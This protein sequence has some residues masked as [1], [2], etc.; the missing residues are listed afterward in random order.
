MSC[1][2]DYNRS[3]PTGKE[4][5][6]PCSA[7]K[8]RHRLRRT[9]RLRIVNRQS[10]IVNSPGFSLVEIMIVVVIMGLLAGVV[11]VSV[12]GYLTKAKQAT[13]KQEIATIVKALESFYGEYSRYPTADEGLQILARPSEKFPEALL[14]RDPVDP[15][16][17]PYQYNIPGTDGHRYEVICY[18]EDGRDG[19]EGVD[20]DISS[21]DLKKK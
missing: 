13:V 14:D 18:G 9:A 21:K 8:P 6:L 7:S 3:V 5:P 17:K 15:W 12:R 11:T 4:A 2:D 10:S 1:R 20:A 16:G 19:G